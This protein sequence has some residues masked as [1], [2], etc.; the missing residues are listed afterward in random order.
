MWRYVP[1]DPEQGRLLKYWIQLEMKRVLF[2]H[3]KSK[4]YLFGRLQYVQIK[5]KEKH[6][7]WKLFSL[8][9]KK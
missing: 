3:K 4:K 2:H 9:K 7:N 1:P 8:F 5:L 6:E